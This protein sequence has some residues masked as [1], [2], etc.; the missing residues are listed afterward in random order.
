MIDTVRESRRSSALGIAEAVNVCWVP[1]EYSVV[2]GRSRFGM[3]T[4]SKLSC[5]L[6]HT[7]FVEG[8]GLQFDSSKLGLACWN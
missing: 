5:T 1:N 2:S 3:P 4:Q 8:G 6:C 7:H